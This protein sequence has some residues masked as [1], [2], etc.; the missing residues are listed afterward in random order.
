MW[1]IFC[2]ALDGICGSIHNEEKEEE[3][4][5]CGGGRVF[6]DGKAV[7][8]NVWI[9]DAIVTIIRGTI[10]VVVVVLLDDDERADEDDFMVS[11]VCNNVIM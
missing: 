3:V 6:V 4:C 1:N 5:E 8:R 9:M 10:I 7:Q 2:L 11:S